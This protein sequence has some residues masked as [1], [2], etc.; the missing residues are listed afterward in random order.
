M[1]DQFTALVKAHREKNKQIRE[2]RTQ[3]DQTL[4]APST[5]LVEDSVRSEYT[6][7]LENVDLADLFNA[8]ICSPTVPLVI[9]G[10]RIKLHEATLTY[11]E[12]APV[13]LRG[14]DDAILLLFNQDGKP[15]PTDRMA[16]VTLRTDPT[17]T[18]TLSLTK[19]FIG[20]RVGLA[21]IEQGVLSGIAFR[22]SRMD[23]SLQNF[24]AR[25]EVA[26]TVLF[27]L[28]NR[29]VDSD[30][31]IHLITVDPVLARMFSVSEMSS[32]AMNVENYER[33]VVTFYYFYKGTPIPF[34]QRI[35]SYPFNY[36]APFF[37][38]FSIDVP[39]M[40]AAF[41]IHQA[42][43]RLI[44]IYDQ[45]KDLVPSLYFDSEEV[46]ATKLANYDD[47]ENIL[48]LQTEAAE[49]DRLVSDLPPEIFRAQKKEGST[50]TYGRACQN[51][52]RIIDRLPDGVS[53]DDPRYLLFPEKE[54]GGVKPQ[55]YS[56]DHYAKPDAV[57][58]PPQPKIAPTKKKGKAAE[59]AAEK[60]VFVSS[61]GQRFK[62]TDVGG[63]GD[64]FFRSVAAALGDDPE[65]HMEYRMKIVEGMI[66]LKDS[67]AIETQE[68]DIDFSDLFQQ[69]VWD[70]DAMDY[71]PAFS[72][73]IIGRT[74]VIHKPDGTP[75]QTFEVPG[76]EPIHLLHRGGN[77]YQ[78]LTPL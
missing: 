6:Y 45:R 5:S 77:H 15:I 47:V 72:H 40:K 50:M 51:P 66:D 44:T 70:K 60:D 4:P 56:C 59:K 31:L 42:I 75:D 63:G 3:F 67:G 36:D 16:E 27:G 61:T 55:W 24:V 34:K 21:A 71:V 26:I 30:I 78:L 19:R 12:A 8:I 32:G 20:K 9:Y 58:A 29:A 2:A 73:E 11:D 57:E 74:I 41:D 52:P 76:T 53:E 25:K 69:G 39:S 37:F 64:C 1:T 49:E 23:Y 33:P 14:V 48:A 68:E 35:E 65:N 13:I 54:I 7:A 17:L 18:A 38:T 62:V 22:P 43:L 46:M 10:P 28:P